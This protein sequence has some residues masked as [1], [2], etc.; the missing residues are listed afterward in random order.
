MSQITKIDDTESRIEMHET[1]EE[2]FDEHGDECYGYSSSSDV[3]NAAWEQA[4]KCFNRQQ[5]LN[6]TF[7]E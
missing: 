5:E 4:M 7:E 2:W 3:W 1:F 6:G